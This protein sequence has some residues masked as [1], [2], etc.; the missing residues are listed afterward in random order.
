MSRWSRWLRVSEN[1]TSAVPD[2]CET[3]TSA[4][5]IGGPGVCRLNGAAETAARG[6]GS[7]HGGPGGFACVDEILKDPVDGVFV[8]N[9][10]VTVGVD[11]QFERLEFHTGFARHVVNGNGAKVRKLGFRTDCRVFLDLDGDFITGK[12]IGPC[13]QWREWCVCPAGGVAFRV[14]GV[15]LRSAFHGIH[16]S[17]LRAAFSL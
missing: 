16:V 2:A 15:V 17:R 13:L 8:K 1:T 14:R 11:V 4:S 5:C 7:G 6:K 10:D 12:L 3:P 9:A